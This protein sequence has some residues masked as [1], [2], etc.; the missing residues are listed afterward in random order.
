MDIRAYVAVISEWI[1]AFAASWLLSLSPRLRTPPVQ[2]KYARRD[3]LIALSLYVLTLIFVF[4]YYAMN[5]P[6][7][8]AT[9]PL[10]PAP[11]HPTGRNLFIAAVCLVVFLV[12]LATRRQPILSIGWKPALIRPGLEMGAALAILT[13][14][15]HNR[16]MAVLS[17]ISGDAGRGLLIALG[18]SL[19][20]ETIFRGYIQLRLGSWL[21][22]WQGVLLTAA[23]FAIWHLPAWLNHLPT[24]TLLTLLGLTFIQ[25]L[26]L[27]WVMEKGKSVAA[28]AL[29]RTLSIW[30]QF[31]G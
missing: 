1:G 12:A 29:Y 10:V 6:V 28:P 30:M 2:F 11:A 23:L 31:L 9:V 13:V 26:V 25:G 16:V 3:G 27:G 18:I 22:R 15:L 24:T 5:P 7:F 14:F 8:P 21:G 20:E 19:C 17:G 4:V